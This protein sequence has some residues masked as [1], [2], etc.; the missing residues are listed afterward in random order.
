M[1]NSGNGRARLENVI[2][3]MAVGLVAISVLSII[4]LMLLSRVID[5]SSFILVP[6]IGLPTSALLI[7]ILLTLQI[8]KKNKTD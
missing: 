3:A 2:A 7:I 6:Y 4:G 8:R 5:T 1:A